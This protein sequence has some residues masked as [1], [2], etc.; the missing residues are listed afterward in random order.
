MIHHQLK[1]TTICFEGVKNKTTICTKHCLFRVHLLLFLM[2]NL[3]KIL[4]NE[5]ACT[6]M[7]LEITRMIFV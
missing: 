5:N 7:L 4:T 1:Q 2:L 6:K 3:Q